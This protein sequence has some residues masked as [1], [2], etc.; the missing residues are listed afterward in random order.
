MGDVGEVGNGVIFCCL[1]EE[2]KDT[3]DVSYLAID[4]TALLCRIRSLMTSKTG[5][6][7]VKISHIMMAKWILW[8]VRIHPRGAMHMVG[9][10]THH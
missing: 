8:H 6:K 4:L 10:W 5:T 1:M 7:T 9:K 3:T 2:E